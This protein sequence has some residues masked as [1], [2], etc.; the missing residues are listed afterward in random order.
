MLGIFNMPLLIPEN[1]T[2]G[3]LIRPVLPTFNNAFVNRNP[4]Y[5][6]Q[7]PVTVLP[8]A[9]MLGKNN[10]PKIFFFGACFFHPNFLFLFAFGFQ[11][12]FD[13]SVKKRVR[14]HRARAKFRVE[15]YRNKIRVVG[16]FYDFRQYIFVPT[17]YD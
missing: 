2:A 15:L 4:A 8:T 10:A 13:K 5:L 14:A 16:A 9:A 3:R 6:R 12:G 11:T 1:N 17:R 7:H